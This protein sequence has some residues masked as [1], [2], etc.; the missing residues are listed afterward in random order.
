MTTTS[1]EERE[2]IQSAINDSFRLGQ[3][4]G[5]IQNLN[6]VKEAEIEHLKARIAEIESQMSVVGHKNPAWEAGAQWGL[7]TMPD[8]IVHAFVDLSETEHSDNPL[9]Y[10]G[11]KTLYDI[12]GGIMRGYIR[13]KI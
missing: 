1:D 9:P 3:E 2:F 6:P 12:V 7:Y 13:G 5:R 8:E 10:D 4:A 11:L